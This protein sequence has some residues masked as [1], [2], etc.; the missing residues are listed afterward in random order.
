MHSSPRN[1]LTVVQIVT[2]LDRFGRPDPSITDRPCLPSEAP[3]IIAEEM[4]RNPYATAY[5]LDSHGR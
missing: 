3:R 4:R 2:H 1:T 5:V